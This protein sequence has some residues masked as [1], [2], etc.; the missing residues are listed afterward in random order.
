MTR[1]EDQ[2]AMDAVERAGRALRDV[3][4]PPGPSP[5]IVASTVEALQALDNPPDVARRN[6]RRE[7]M[8][9]IGRYSGVAA[10]IC[11][12]VVGGWLLFSGPGTN[13]SFAQVIEKVREAK[14]FSYEIVAEP[15]GT[16]KNPGWEKSVMKV[17]FREPGLLREERPGGDVMIQNI[18]AG[19]TLRYDPS[20]KKAILFPFKPQAPWLAFRKF[21]LDEGRNWGDGAEQRLGER[22]VDGTKAQGF[23]VRGD[24]NTLWN[25]WADA[26]TGKLLRLEYVTR[27]WKTV[28]SKIVLNPDLPDSLFSVEPPEGYD[29]TV[30]KDKA[31]G[32]GEMTAE[33]RRSLELEKGAAREAAEAAMR[34]AVQR[35]ADAINKDKKAGSQ[36]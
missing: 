8:F 10:A 12:L 14:S 34:Q 9:R 19:K 31:S 23:A 3:R 11:L 4:V 21:F 22:E 20:T 24:A 18:T 25:I 26:K 30:W 2:Q 1:R 15:I 16:T 28:T 33:Q 32:S 36:K 17:Y 35:R 7:L 5:T 27:D 6:A 29:L 13:V